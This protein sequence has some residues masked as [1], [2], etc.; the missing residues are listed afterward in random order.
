MLEFYWAYADYRQMMDLTEELLSGLADEAK[1][2]LG[3][4]TL[5]WDG[6]E[7][8]WARPW[9][10]LTMRE[11]IAK[12]G[13]VAPERLEDVEAVSAELRQRGL[14]IPP[15]GTYGHCLMALFEEIVEPHLFQ[16]TFVTD[17]PVE[18]SPLSKQRPDDPR[19]TERFEL[20]IGRMEMANAFSELNDPDVQAERFREQLTAREKGDAEAHRFD[21]DYVRALEHAMPPAA[22]I[23][24]GIDR[25]TMLLADRASIRDV[26]LFPLLRPEAE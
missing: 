26:I 24:I 1:R 22:G 23:G 3:K 17:H 10:R 25:L 5:T 14:D 7:I 11:A 9:A 20:Y 13:G 15:G 12:F 4:E 19:F 6:Q 2:V 16:P 18:V 21:A 8:E